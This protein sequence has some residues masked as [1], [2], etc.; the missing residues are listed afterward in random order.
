MEEKK[1]KELEQRSFENAMLSYDT[2]NICCL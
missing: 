1:L 2:K